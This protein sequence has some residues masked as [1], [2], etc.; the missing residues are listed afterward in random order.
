MA[1]NVPSPSSTW[2]PAYQIRVNQALESNDITNRKKNTDIELGLAEKL[3]LRSPDGAR[4][5]ITVSNTGVL[6][7]TAL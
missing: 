2:T 6:G 1:L 7:A 5:Q 3:I 4:W